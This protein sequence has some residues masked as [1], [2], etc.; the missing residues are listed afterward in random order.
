MI[1]LRVWVLP[2]P[3]RCSPAFDSAA[4]LARFH[5]LGTRL[6][7]TGYLLS[8]V[9][10]PTWLPPSHRAR[11][12]P[13]APFQTG[14][15]L[16]PGSKSL[17]PGTAAR[18]CGRGLRAR[19]QKQG[20]H[21]STFEIVHPPLPLAGNP[22]GNH[23][24]QARLPH[25][26]SRPRLRERPRETITL[27]FSHSTRYTLES[28][29]YPANTPRSLTGSNLRLLYLG[30]CVNALPQTPSCALRSASRKERPPVIHPMCA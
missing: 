25:C 11:S 10:G 12:P 8:A 2:D 27:P 21:P 18:T 3:L 17:A 4:K 20:P 22:P 23:P 29:S 6:S 26:P 5:S 13:R 30:M 19:L 28:G 9:D 24:S 7:H 14:S 16:A 15:Y 1:G